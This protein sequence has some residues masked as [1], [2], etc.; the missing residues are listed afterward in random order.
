MAINYAIIDS[1]LCGTLDSWKFS[2][3]NVN[4]NYNV[5]NEEPFHLT[6]WVSLSPILYFPEA[7]TL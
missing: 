1:I 4:N 3:F 5:W 2:V 7:M 6:K